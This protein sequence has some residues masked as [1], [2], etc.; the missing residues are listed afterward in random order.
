MSKEVEGA[1]WLRCHLVPATLCHNIV[2][3]V[4]YHENSFEH[5]KGTTTS[6]C[7]M[8]FIDLYLVFPRADPGFFLGGGALVSCSTS[9]PIKF[10][11]FFFLQNTGCIRKLQVIS[12]GEGAYPPRPIRYFFRAGAK[13]IRYC[14]TIALNTRD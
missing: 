4:N 8:S 6:N 5:L 2:R 7:R 3:G 12:G 9:T 1:W 13:V 14:V 11:F 10:C